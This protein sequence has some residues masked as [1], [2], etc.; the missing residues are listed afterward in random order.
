[1]VLVVAMAG[2]QEACGLPAGDKACALMED[3]PVEP[4]DRASCQGVGW[5]PTG[6]MAA[7]HTCNQFLCWQSQH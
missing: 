2:G 7:G 6:C 3:E 5:K 4:P 1:M